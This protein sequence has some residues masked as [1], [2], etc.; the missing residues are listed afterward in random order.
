MVTRRKILIGAGITTLGIGSYIYDRG[1][2]LPTLHLDPQALNNSF[3]LKDGVQ[4]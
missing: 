1:L 4:V 2:R 3:S